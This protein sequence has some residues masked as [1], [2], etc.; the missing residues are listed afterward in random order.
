MNKES[1]VLATLREAK[2]EELE[3]KRQIFIEYL[4]EKIKEE[5]WHAVAD[6][7]CDIREVETKMKTLQGYWQ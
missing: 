1:Q 4:T 3:K 6:A 2:L 5:D 7:C